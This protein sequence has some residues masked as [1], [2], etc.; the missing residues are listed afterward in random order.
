[1]R[2]D[3]YACREHAVLTQVFWGTKPNLP[4][5]TGESQTPR[6][7]STCRRAKVCALPARL[8]RSAILPRMIELLGLLLATLASPLRS[9][10]RLLLEN[11]LLRQQL[12][13]ALRGQRRPR[14]RTRDKL[15][16][17]RVRRLHRNW[18]RH[19]LLVRPATVL[20]WHRQG[21]RLF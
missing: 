16:W 5:P 21:W 7:R 15:F 19:L 17:L 10:Q 11:L 2:D 3:R 13:V 12:Q 18:R 6:L 8:W 20:H 14:L 9:R 1:M 4:I